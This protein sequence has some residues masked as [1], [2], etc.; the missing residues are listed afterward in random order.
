MADGVAG[1]ES[2]ME[3]VVDNCRNIDHASFVIEPGKLNIKFAPNGTGKSSIA[4]AL[5]AWTTH[6]I[7]DDLVPF[8]WQQQGSA[9]EHS[10][11]VSGIDSDMAA[12]I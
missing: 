12:Q 5:T 3:V 11:K 9:K 8:K 10:L 7:S 6:N 1:V 4:K 2:P